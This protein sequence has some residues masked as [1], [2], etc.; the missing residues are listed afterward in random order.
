[1]KLG[2]RR[3]RA[4]S[5]QRDT[6]CNTTADSNSPATASMGP[7][8]IWIGRDGKVGRVNGEETGR[9]WAEKEEREGVKKRGIE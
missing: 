6:V 3:E 5:G 2:H 8:T 4:S 7:K 1:M 9:V